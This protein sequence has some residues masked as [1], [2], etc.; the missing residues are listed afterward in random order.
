MG[1]PEQ[2]LCSKTSNAVFGGSYL[3]GNVDPCPQRNL[4][5]IN[6]QLHRIKV[7]HTGKTKGSDGNIVAALR[8]LARRRNA[9]EEIDQVLGLGEAQGTI[10]QRS[11][12]EVS[13]GL[14]GS[15]SGSLAND[16]YELP[17]VQTRVDAMN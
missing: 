17:V 7:N 4:S 11:G 9:Q 16:R 5:Q 15:A 6:N 12:K 1:R 8:I 2:K 10:P 3:Q 14:Q 13:S